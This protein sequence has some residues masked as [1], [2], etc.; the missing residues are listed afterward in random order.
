MVEPARAGHVY[1]V[2]LRNG[3][4]AHYWIVLTDPPM[5][6]P[7][8]IAVSLTDRHNMPAVDDIWQYGYR[9]CPGFGLSKPSVLKLDYAVLQTQSWLDRHQ[10]EFVCLCT[11]ESLRRARCNVIWYQQFLPPKVRR[12]ATSRF[13]VWDL[14]CGPP[15]RRGTPDSPV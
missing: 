6:D 4:P 11:D 2:D 13:A 15:P 10:A 12:F 7:T 14:D 8:F 9:L 1:K 3:R 5:I